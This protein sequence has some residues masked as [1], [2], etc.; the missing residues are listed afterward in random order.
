MTLPPVA[1]ELEPDFKAACMHMFEAARAACRGE[2]NNERQHRAVAVETCSAA[3]E[4]AE[5]R[6]D[7]VTAEAF[8]RIAEDS[9]DLPLYGNELM[10]Y[11]LLKRAAK[12]WSRILI[13][14]QDRP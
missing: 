12:E 6:G 11:A 9:A 5:E 14:G 8:R 2:T 1:A 7:A 3:A 4:Y 13:D 10:V